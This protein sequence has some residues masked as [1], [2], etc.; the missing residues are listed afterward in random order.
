[1]GV[2]LLT[3]NWVFMVMAVAVVGGTVAR[4]PREEQMMIGEFGE[5]YRAYRKRTR[6]FFPRWGAR[7]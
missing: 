1:V 3:A 4:V 7:G 2:A 5:E 6:R